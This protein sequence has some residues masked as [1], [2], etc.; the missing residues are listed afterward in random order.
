MEKILNL[1]KIQ[2]AKVNNTYFPFFSVTNSFIDNEISKRLTK[3]FPSISRG[4]SF[5]IEA[6][7]SGASFIQLV[8]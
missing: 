6:L 1:D 2:E 5:P 3:D 7:K 8:E 4:G